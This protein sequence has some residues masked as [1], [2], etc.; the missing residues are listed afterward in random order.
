VDC[1]ACSGGLLPSAEV[2]AL[3]LPPR[4]QRNPGGGVDRLTDASDGSVAAA[5][6]WRAV[7]AARLL[8]QDPAASPRRKRPGP[9]TRPDLR[10]FVVGATGFEP[11]T[12]SVSVNVGLPLCYPPFPQVVADRRWQS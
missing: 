12:P 4:M 6:V 11:V 8:P 1:L 9:R 10:R 5:G 2:S 7:V 3:V